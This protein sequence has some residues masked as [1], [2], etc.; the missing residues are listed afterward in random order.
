MGKGQGSPMG[1]DLLGGDLF[2][3]MGMK[4][5]NLLDTPKAAEPVA[6]EDSAGATARIGDSAQG[7]QVRIVAG[8][9]DSVTT[10]KLTITNVPPE[11]S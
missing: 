1:G 9:T 2:A 6:I 11:I 4:K 3:L 5:I 8:S 10:V 7:V